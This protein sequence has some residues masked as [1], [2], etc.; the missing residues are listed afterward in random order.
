MGVARGYDD[1]TGHDIEEDCGEARVEGTVYSG[2]KRAYAGDTRAIVPMNR[3]DK[4]DI[5]LVLPCRFHSGDNIPLL[6]YFSSASS[7]PVHHD[8][9]YLKSIDNG[10][11]PAVTLFPPNSSLA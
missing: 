5:A 11:L 3:F 7:S 10:V 1:S 9:R 6:I 8:N 2:H 4:H